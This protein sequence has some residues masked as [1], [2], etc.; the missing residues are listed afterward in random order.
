[1]FQEFTSNNVTFCHLQG[2]LIVVVL[3]IPVFTIFLQS[4]DQQ[5]FLQGM[6][7]VSHVSIQY[8]LYYVVGCDIIN[9]LSPHVAPELNNPRVLFCTKAVR[10]DRLKGKET[11]FALHSG[12]WCGLDQFLNKNDVIKEVCYV[13]LQL[14][15]MCKFAIRCWM[16]CWLRKRS[17]MVLTVNKQIWTLYIQ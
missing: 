8:I 11:S 6:W 13:W 10:G 17:R 9:V 16:R 7:I 12:S 14:V 1:M 2:L 5:N 15:D 3:H 4:V